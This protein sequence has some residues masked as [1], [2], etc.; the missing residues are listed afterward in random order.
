MSEHFWAEEII[1]TY[2]A[3]GLEP[4]ERERL[5]RHVA[6][7]AECA[8]ALDVAR[9]NDQRLEALFVPVRPDGGLEERMIREL[10][11]A[12]ARRGFRPLPRWGK[13]VA[14]VAAMLLLGACGAGVVAVMEEGLLEPLW[15]DVANPDEQAGES[16]WHYRSY[17]RLNP[18]TPLGMDWGA[19]GVEDYRRSVLSAEKKAEEIV[20]SLIDGTIPNGRAANKFKNL[21]GSAL[22]LEMMGDVAGSFYGRSGATRNVQPDKDENWAYREHL[23]D[24][25]AG[26]AASVYGLDFSPDGKKLSSAGADK[27]ELPK[28]EQGAEVSAPV[29]KNPLESVGI[30]DGDK[31][32]PPTN[33]P[34]P[35][36]IGQGGPIAGIPL[37][38][39]FWGRSDKT[40]ESQL[41]IPSYFKPGDT[42]L[43]KR[44]DPN[45]LYNIAA[46]PVGEKKVNDEPKKDKKPDPQ[47]TE[48]AKDPVAQ[49]AGRKIIR[50]GEVD[51]EVESFDDSVAVI[52]T[53]VRATN[54]GFI[55][56][57]NS[58]K[59]ANGKVR[60]SVVIRV[61]PDELDKLVLDLRKELGKKGELKGQ[62]I[63][64][65]DVTKQYTDM[66]SRLRA[67][68]TMEDRLLK[69]IKDGKGEIKDLVAAEKELGVWRTRIE[70]LEGELR[71]YGNLVSLS[72]LTV[73]LSE[74]EIRTAAA[75]AERERVQAGIE[76]EDVE[77]AYQDALKTIAELKGRVTKSELKQHAAGQLNAILHFEVAPESAGLMRDRLRQ[78]GTMARLEV[79][80][81]QEAEG[82]GKMPLT[83]KVNRGDTQFLVSIYNLANV[84]PRETIAIQIAA[85]DVPKAFA[86]L[87]DAVAKAKGRVINSNLSEKD[88][89]NISAAL[90]FDIRR[91]GESAVQTALNEAGELLSRT[92]NRVPEGDNVSDAKV[93]YKLD[94]MPASTI[95]PR[96]T[97]KL[98]LEVADVALTL[99]AFSE[100]VKESKGR[101]VVPA[102]IAQEK[103]GRVTALVVY[104]VPLSA[105]PGVIEE[106]KKSG[107]VRVH[108][109]TPNPQAPEGKLALARI[110]VV[111]SNELLVP[112]DEGLWSQI[113]NG[114]SFSLRG[115]SL[116]ASWLIVGILF[117]LPWV[118]LLW[119]VVWVG[120]KVLRK[121]AT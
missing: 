20:G 45:D 24:A 119:V 47:K 52:V 4:A 39:S 97:T 2:L 68:R 42:F 49:P 72:T 65:Q 106:F 35:G 113:R 78:L 33:L 18:N 98:G 23:R 120:R 53:L 101:I 32:N 67:A 108:D 89:Q 107:Q 6:E 114:I 41:K 12:P 43:K 61:P 22:H 8:G 58:D 27:M 115:L 73:N 82:A 38:G 118:L 87:R 21:P 111:M 60:G 69:I 112:R 92:A 28:S 55:A 88:R 94:I 10:R 40:R 50:S 75:V 71:Y 17:I 110:E 44:I 34:A 14:G 93:H 29:Q 48:P 37:A 121:R 116:S 76:V 3:G 81:V 15:A 66:E 80:R 90:E 36:G 1:E 102:R 105:G 103:S 117:V 84:Q 62:R 109:V 13:I 74:K 104:D 64:S 56:T 91:T 25:K 51:F 99:K 5:E 26:Q 59:L 86:D 46:A 77:K 57:V 31:S 95:P 7:C 9:V 63:G 19:D 83:G 11:A 79:D 85:T 54:G 96:E 70:E 30:R 100:T 16:S